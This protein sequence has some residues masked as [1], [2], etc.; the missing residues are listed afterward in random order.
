M[1]HLPCRAFDRSVHNSE[2]KKT[3]IAVRFVILKNA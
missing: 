2:I 3:A 1:L